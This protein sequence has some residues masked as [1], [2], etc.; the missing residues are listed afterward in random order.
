MNTRLQIYMVA[1]LFVSFASCK[2]QNQTDQLKEN[3]SPQKNGLLESI[4]PIQEVDTI[5]TTNAPSR[6]T[7]QIRKDKE[8][9]LLFAAY[10]D[11][12]RYDGNA[13]YHYPLGVNCMK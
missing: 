8:G 3:I 4:H 9:K 12:I 2:G 1:I 11:I 5:W 7:R 10:E 13:A 6:I